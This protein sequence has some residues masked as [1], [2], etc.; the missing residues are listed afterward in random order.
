LAIGIELRKGLARRND[1]VT[2]WAPGVSAPTTAS[3]QEQESAGQL[4]EDRE[5]VP[6][7]GQIGSMLPICFGRESLEK[8]EHE[9]DVPQDP[10]DDVSAL[11]RLHTQLAL[12]TSA[13][14]VAAGHP[15]TITMLAG[16]RET[17]AR[18]AGLLTFAEPEALAAIDRALEHA[19]VGQYNETCSELVHAHRRLAVLL[20]RDDRPRRTGAAGESTLRWRLGAS[21]EP[22]A[23]EPPDSERGQPG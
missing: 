11:Y 21:P 18:A 9:V 23:S 13:V 2:R 20:R 22:P 8:G 3:H 5:R 17:T 15:D 4:R 12:L 19:V 1:T 14:T 16:L 10:A 6:R 7:G